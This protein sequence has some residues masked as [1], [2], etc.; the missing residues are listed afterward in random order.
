[1][2]IGHQAQTLGLGNWV[3]YLFFTFSPKP[4]FTHP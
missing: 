2:S 3:Y 4:I 1:M